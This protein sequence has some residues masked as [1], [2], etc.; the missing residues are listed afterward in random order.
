MREKQEHNGKDRLLT[1]LYETLGYCGI[2][3]VAIALIL[4]G[5]DLFASLE[6][7]GE[8]VTRTVADWLEMV[9]P[10]AL[11]RL[12]AALQRGPQ[13][14]SVAV[15]WVFSVYAWVYPGLTGVVLVFFFGKVRE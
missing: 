4:L 14:A 1:A 7:G 10:T 6:A 13:M 9:D 12:V 3:L 2:L 8:I 11:Q 15:Q 5:A